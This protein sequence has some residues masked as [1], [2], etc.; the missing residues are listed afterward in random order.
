M[1][2][3]AQLVTHQMVQHRYRSS[4]KDIG[5]ETVFI[6]SF[7]DR[8]RNVYYRFSL[9]SEM[10]FIVINLHHGWTEFCSISASSSMGQNFPLSVFYVF[11][12]AST[13]AFRR[14]RILTRHMWLR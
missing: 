1:P 4:F 8:R 6:S 10:R 11:F 3:R 9:F 7:L 14:A 5:R 13:Y 2:Q 12:Q